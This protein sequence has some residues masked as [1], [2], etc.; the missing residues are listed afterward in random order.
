VNKKEAGRA[1]VGSSSSFK[2]KKFLKKFLKSFK[3]V[4]KSKKSLIS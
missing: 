3:R 1:G 2:K 4:L